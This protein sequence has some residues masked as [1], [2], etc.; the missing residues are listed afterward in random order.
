[1]GHWKSFAIFVWRA[2]ADGPTA[3]EVVAFGNQLMNTR[4]R[5]SPIHVVEESAGLPTAEGRD[6]L[7]APAR[8]HQDR[9]GCIGVLLPEAHL[10]AA[11]MRVFVRSARV[12]LRGQVETVV[13]PTLNEL[14]SEVLEVHA[15]RTGEHFE[16]R[17]LAA[18][19]EAVRRLAATPAPP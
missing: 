1:M 16:A 6:G 7:L 11:M 18:A 4:P 9:L 2:R 17:E 15:R 3:R 8:V 5:F 19:I 14:V 10:V 13:A 12:I